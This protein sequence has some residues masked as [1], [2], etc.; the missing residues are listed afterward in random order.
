MVIVHHTQNQAGDHC[1]VVAN[2]SE[3]VRNAD[4]EE[5]TSQHD[6]SPISDCRPS[7]HHAADL[8]E[9]HAFRESTFL[10]IVGEADCEI[11]TA[12]E[13]RRNIEPHH[14]AGCVSCKTQA[15]QCNDQ[16]QTR[17]GNQF[18]FSEVLFENHSNKSCS[19]HQEQELRNAHNHLRDRTPE[20]HSD[21]KPLFRADIRRTQEAH[22]DIAGHRK[23][24]PAEDFFFCV[25]EVIAA[26]V[27]ID[28]GNTECLRGIVP[29]NCNEIEVHEIAGESRK[30]QPE[31][32]NRNTGINQPGAMEF[33]PFAIFGTA[34]DSHISS[35]VVRVGENM[36]SEI[37][38]D[39]QCLL[40]TGA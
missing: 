38:Q 30:R 40:G 37:R 26:L 19:Q 16:N 12:M 11:L 22:D 39:N 17:N 24:E 7:L 25:V 33:E 18:A 34:P 27:A 15:S 10:Q 32:E 36:L 9:R 35:S 31:R 1:V 2:L 20:R 28:Q 21:S 3:E 4:I 6:C 13:E 8:R 23:N 29:E 14:Q 5:A